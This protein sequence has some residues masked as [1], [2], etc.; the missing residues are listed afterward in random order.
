MPHGGWYRA[1]TFR[2]LIGKPV[3]LVLFF[4]VSSIQIGMREAWIF[5]KKLDTRCVCNG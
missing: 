3:H 5:S 4:L 2:S 1:I